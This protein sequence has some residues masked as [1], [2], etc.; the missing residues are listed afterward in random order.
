MI[1]IKDLTKIYN[2]SKDSQV[3]ALDKINLRFPEV[4][5][6]FSCGESG[7]GKT[8]LFNLIASLDD[9]NEGDIIIDGNSI[10]SFTPSMCEDY[11]NKSIGFIFQDYSLINSI[12]YLI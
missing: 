3:I 10:K 4:G 2:R 6:I 7:S 11:R 8:T 12:F 5:M 9:I 1:E